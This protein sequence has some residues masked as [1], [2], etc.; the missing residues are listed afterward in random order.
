MCVSVCLC[1]QDPLD[2]PVAAPVSLA[3]YL[4]ANL[5]LG[6][7]VWFSAKDDM[8][9]LYGSYR[10]TFRSRFCHSLSNATR[11]TTLTHHGRRDV[12]F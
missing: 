7:A 5:T 3:P 10:G 6:N 1:A 9:Y 12:L 2:W 11:G 4:S 8:V